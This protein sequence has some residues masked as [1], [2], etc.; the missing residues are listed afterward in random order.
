MRKKSFVNW[1][2]YLASLLP[3]LYLL[4]TWN[5]IPDII[6]VSLDEEMAPV[7]YGSK[8]YLFVP[9]LVI[10]AVACLV[11]LLLTNI[12]RIDPKQKGL[13]LSPTF[14][15]LALGM[16]VFMTALNFIVLLAMINRTV[17]WTNFIFPLIGLLFAFV[18]NYMNNIRPNYFAGLRLPWTLNDDDNWRRTH[19]F[20][21]KLWFWGGIL[22]MVLGIFLEMRVFMVVFAAIIMVMVII[23]AVYSYRIFRDKK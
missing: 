21:G 19:H 23:P 18:G 22:M 8:N 13:P 4:I 7:E 20:A 1:L 14:R 16:L 10:A 17:K 15:K 3:L 12:H 5:S 9:A 11:Y 6:P 2:P